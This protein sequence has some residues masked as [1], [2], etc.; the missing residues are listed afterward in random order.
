MIVQP[1]LNFDGRCEEALNFYKQAVGAE[2]QVLLRMSEAPAEFEMGED[3]ANQVMHSCFRVG[4]TNIMASDC[5]GQ[6]KPTFEG[7]SLSILADSGD[8]ATQIFNALSEGGQVEQPLTATF[9]AS[10]FGVVKD[11]FGVSWMV[12]VPLPQQAQ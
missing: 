12:H 4:D 2:V 8:E 5:H 6:G 10:H 11:R 7:F 9:F 3:Q 1:Y